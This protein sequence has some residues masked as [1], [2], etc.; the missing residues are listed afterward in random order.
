M[1]PAA[2]SGKIFVVKRPGKRFAW[3]AIP[4]VG[5]ATAGDLD[6][7]GF[8]SLA[9]LRGRDPLR[10]YAALCKKTESRQDPCVLDVFM[11]L[12][13]LADTGE[14]RNWWSFT[15]ERKRRY[16]E[17]SET[18]KPRRAKPAARKKR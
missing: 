7:L 13:H 16:P 11:M 5:P 15:K 8:K 6:L 4:G 17:I 2:R 1:S 3:T 18:K 10:L 12:T 14:V 9:R